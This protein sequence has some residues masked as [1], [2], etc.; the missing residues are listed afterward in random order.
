MTK[1]FVANGGRQMKQSSSYFKA[2]E[3]CHHA[4]AKLHKKGR[5]ALLPWDDLSE[6]EKSIKY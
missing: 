3:L 5:V 4:I 6:D 1:D 2:K